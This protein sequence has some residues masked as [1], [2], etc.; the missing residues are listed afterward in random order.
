[1]TIPAAPDRGRTITH[2]AV[3]VLILDGVLL[4]F[5][6]LWSRTL[7]AGIAG[8]A[9][10]LVAGGVLLLWRHQRRTIAELADARQQMR[11]EARALRDL[12][13]DQQG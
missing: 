5:I 1:M 8:G 9:C 4:L 13:R 6:W 2:F 3:G 11:E 12:L 10:L 7:W